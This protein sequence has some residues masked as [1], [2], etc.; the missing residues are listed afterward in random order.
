MDTTSKIHDL[1]TLQ[2][3]IIRWRL[4]SDVIVFT[5]GCFDILHYGHIEYLEKAK[6]LG[7]KLIVAV[8]SDASVQ[9]LKGKHRP[10]QNQVSRSR[11]LSALQCV[12]AVIIF[13][14]DTPY[15]LLSCICPDILVKGGDYTVEQII[16]RE[17]AK[18]VEIVPFVEGYS[19]SLIEQKIKQS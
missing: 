16:G 5:N 9:R 19:T 3:E 4:K 1:D 17:W 11:V 13:D 7:D 14:E 6:S 18:K 8:N 10:I 12:D 15:Q 2:S